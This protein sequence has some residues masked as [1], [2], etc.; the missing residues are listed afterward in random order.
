MEVI[1]EGVETED[2]V[3]RLNSLKCEYIQGYFYSKPLEVKVFEDLLKKCGG[4][5]VDYISEK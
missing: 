3:E 2:Q 5:L 4:N 1:A